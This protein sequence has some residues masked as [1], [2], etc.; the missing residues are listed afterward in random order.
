M[1]KQLDIELL[2]GQQ[3]R[4]YR[5]LLNHKISVQKYIKGKG[6]Q[7]AGHCINLAISQVSFSVFEAGRQR[8]IRE[9]Q[10]NVHAFAIGIVVGVTVPV[11]APIDLAYD[12]YSN[13]H[14]FERS[15]GKPIVKANY[16]IVK[17]N[18]VGVTTDALLTIPRPL[19]LTLFE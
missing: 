17:D 13:D 5:N 6:W 12:P 18:L 2:I 4:I 19:Q 7:L 8:V 16:C 15:T 9:R 10:K 3:V 11:E 1:N 14:F